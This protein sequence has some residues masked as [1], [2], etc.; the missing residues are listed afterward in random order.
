MT[1]FD[2]L[3]R[4]LPDLLSDLAS[5]R[6]PDYF[7]DLLQA[8]ARTRQRPAW[9]SLERWLPVDL[10]LPAPLGRA[11]LAPRLALLLLAALLAAAA[12]IA[13]AGS[14]QVRLPAPF[15]VAANG[16]LLF[17]T[18]GGDIVSA[19]P[20]T[21]NGTTIVAA[22][23]AATADGVIPSRNGRFIVLA[24]K[25][26]GGEQFSIANAD[27]SNVRPLPGTWINQSEIDTS[28]TDSQVAIVSE[29]NGVPSISTIETDGSSFRTLRL[30]LEVN[31]LWYLP[32]GRLLFHGAST[33]GAPTYGLYTVKPDGTGLRGIGQTSTVDDWLAISPSPDGSRLVYHKWVD[34]P[35]EHGR[36]HVVDI[37]SGTD[38]TLP[39]AGA[40]PADE[41]ESATFS[42]DGRTILFK[43]FS[44][45]QNVRLAMMPAAGG[46]AV[47]LGP[48][49][50]YDVSPDA[51]FSPDGRS[52][53]A[54]YPSRG[55][56]W[57]LDP[58]GHSGADRKLPLA[59]V[60]LPTWQ[61]VAP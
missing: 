55:E 22:K 33:S 43:W 41:F 18:A 45:D 24:S 23:A 28:P 32:D 30:G 52:V 54:W 57:L 47:L 14:H 40:T 56:L 8:T 44:A 11:R 10:T 12:L 7:D 58:A 38:T 59:V 3:E 61:R 48:A 37:A 5:A 1:P 17:N 31:S 19:D 9:A 34:L 21:L 25:L 39:V 35:L 20:A 53:I 42:P 27:G 29:I 49:V 51:L 46:T 6:V 50:P 4:H 16:S 36:L 13:Y 60:N 15:G 2:R 26:G